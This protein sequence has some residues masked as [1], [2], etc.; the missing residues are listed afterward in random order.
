M[1]E[2]T[3][4]R[5]GYR[6]SKGTQGAKP[7]CERSCACTRPRRF[8]HARTPPPSLFAGRARCLGQP[9]R[10]DERAGGVQ[11][12]LRQP[13]LLLRHHAVAR[14]PVVRPAARPPRRPALLA[15]VPVAAV[16]RGGERERAFEKTGAPLSLRRVC[17]LL[18][19]NNFFSIT[20]PPSLFLVCSPVDTY[21]NE[22][23]TKANAT[24]CSDW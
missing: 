8:S 14:P 2:A 5:S 13:R 11:L 3:E 4:R 16:A 9:R 12:L 24:S 1:L 22:T 15:P 17:C 19:L 7:R 20:W 18:V 23:L 21:N 10:V 6:R